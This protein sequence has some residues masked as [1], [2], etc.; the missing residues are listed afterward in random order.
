MIANAKPA[1]IQ[2]RKPTV[3]HK[4]AHSAPTFRVDKLLKGLKVGLRTDRSW[5]SWTFIASQWAEAL[6]KDGAEASVFPIAEHIG[7][8]GERAI[9][10]LGAWADT[11]DCAVIGIGT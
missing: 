4:S 11:L 3:E 10:E 7:P 6:R 9:A 5:R 1:K 2:I 8:E